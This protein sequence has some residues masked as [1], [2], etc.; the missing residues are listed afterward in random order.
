MFRISFSSRNTCGLNVYSNILVLIL[1]KT[2]KKNSNLLKTFLFVYAGGYL[3]E[4]EVEK[5]A[6]H[7]E[8]PI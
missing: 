8:I 2:E 6:Q 7:S 1:C 3:L 5:I 4:T